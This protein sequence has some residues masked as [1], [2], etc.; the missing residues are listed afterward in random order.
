MHVMM[1]VSKE[2]SSPAPGANKIKLPKLSIALFEGSYV[3]RLNFWD[4]YDSAVYNDSSR[5]RNIQR[6]TIM[7]TCIKQ[8]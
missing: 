1:N 2:W 5:I 8:F 3:K 7:Y 4:S 6:Y